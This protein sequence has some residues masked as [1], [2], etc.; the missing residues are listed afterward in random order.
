MLDIIIGLDKTQYEIE[1]IIP[2]KCDFMLVLSKH[3]IKTYEFLR[4]N[5]LKQVNTLRFYSYSRIILHWL[6][7]RPDLI[8]INQAGILRGV[9]F[10]NIF[11]KV[12]T[13]CFVTTLEDAK[14]ISNLPTWVF[15]NVKSIISN[16]IFTE[17]VF[18]ST[19]NNR[20]TTILKDKLFYLY[21]S[22]LPKQL[23]KIR[24]YWN[25]SD[26]NC[27]FYIGIIGRIGSSKG[28]DVLLRALQDLKNN[29]F[30]H[31]DRIKVIFIGDF[32]FSEK[33]EFS[34]LIST[35]PVD[36]EVTG[37]QLDINS[38]IMRLHL[39]IIPSRA[40]P[41][42]RIIQEAAEA[43]LPTIVSN[44]GGLAEICVAY[45]YSTVFS[46]PD[47]QEL[48]NLIKYSIEN[49]DSV[50]NKCISTSPD[51]LS[52]FLY[53]DGIKNISNIINNSIKNN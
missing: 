51:F 48:S 45:N 38:Q 42:G 41:F 6:I 14:H 28:H 3:G 37:F 34:K 23:S 52:H 39:L 11:Y 17:N 12:P 4:I 46:Y 9:A 24:P 2:K 22:Y 53:E 40:E 16:S 10:C 26:N 1:V 8:Y 33:E 13:I 20:D 7:K 21:R 44:T 27:N 50:L 36:V 32:S 35:C 30:P 43:Q 15:N 25:F 29:N 47:F 18:C 49:Y 19:I 5:F 31:L